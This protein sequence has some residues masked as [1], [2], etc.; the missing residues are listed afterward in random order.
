MKLL[1]SVA[2][3]ATLLGLC[4]LFTACSGGNTPVQTTLDMEG[5]DIATQYQFDSIDLPVTVVDE[6]QTN[7]MLMGMYIMDVDPTSMTVK[8]HPNR[9]A[10]AHFNVTSFIPLNISNL[11]VDP[12]TNI[13]TI[14]VTLS[15]T[16][17]LDGYDMRLIIYTD[18]SG[19]RLQNPDDWTA[20][21][22][23]AGGMVINPFIAYAKGEQ[24]RKFEGLSQHTETVQ[25]YLPVLVPVN[26]AVDVSYPGNCEEPYQIS[27]D[28]QGVLLDSPVSSVIVTAADLDH[29]DDVNGVSLYCPS[30]TGQ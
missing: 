9:S 21:W 12:I 8:I 27:H 11:S 24:D 25:L 3:L 17:V 2:L 16:F 13:W 20:Q 5:S 10:M 22:D 23:I 1:K 29:Q 26:L 28:I 30:I 15:N 6:N 14:D 19:I 18:N 4:L 7:R